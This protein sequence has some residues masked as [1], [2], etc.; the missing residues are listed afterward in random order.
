M[1]NLE[2]PVGA[3]LQ[4]PYTHMV[5]IINDD[6][7]IT[8]TPII[9]PC[10]AN[11]YTT[12]ANSNYLYLNQGSMTPWTN[13]QAGDTIEWNDPYTG[14]IQREVST[15][16]HFTT[17]SYV[18][19]TN[20]IPSLIYPGTVICIGVATPTTPTPTIAPTPTPPCPCP[21]QPDSFSTSCRWGVGH[22][23]AQFTLTIG[24]LCDWTNV[25]NHARL[26]VSTNNGASWNYLHYFYPSIYTQNHTHS[27]SDTLAN[28][29]IHRIVMSGGDCPYPTP[30]APTPAISGSSCGAI[31]PTSPVVAPTTPT[32]GGGAS[33]ATCGSSASGSTTGDS[34]ATLTPKAAWQTASG[35]LTAEGQI[36][37]KVVAEAVD[38]YVFSFCDSDGGSGSFDTYLCLY[39]DSGVQITSNDDGCWGSS[40]GLKSYIDTNLAI[41]TYYITVAGYGQWDSGAYALKYKRA[42]GSVTPPTPTPTDVSLPPYA[43]TPGAAVTPTVDPCGGGGYSTN[44]VY[45][46]GYESGE[47]LSL[48][49]GDSITVEWP[50][51]NC[52]TNSTY[53]VRVQQGP[54]EAPLADRT[55]S[56]SICSSCPHY[57][58]LDYYGGTSVTFTYNSGAT[59]Y[60]F[61]STT[62]L[63]INQGYRYGTIYVTEMI[64]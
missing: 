55:C 31:T 33:L 58:C 3:L 17:Y 24:P 47:T 63:N 34:V 48:M 53:L 64:Y 6:T 28:T 26:D 37:Y 44:G 21:H 46:N 11:H 56:G 36:V 5:S 16:T 23:T 42:A 50:T 43:P 59:S 14:L 9:S 51:Q 18:T 27:V 22:G 54:N 7:A 49:D 13:L 40:D 45:F 12:Y 62:S 30:I 39:F 57:V 35:S 61:W 32:A 41:G 38:D 4:L 15:V 29:T 25:N 10:G 52:G 2:N 1:I 19:L 8:P 20:P 60:T